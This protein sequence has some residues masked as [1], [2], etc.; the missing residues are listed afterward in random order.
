MQKQ[1]IVPKTKEVE[2][3]RTMKEVIEKII[4]AAP[5]EKAF[6][7][8]ELLLM[9]TDYFMDRFPGNKLEY[10]LKRMGMETTSQI[11]QAISIYMTRYASTK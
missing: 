7:E 10:Q 3:S 8:N 6:N 4:A 9:I 11:R 5:A 2:L 1:T